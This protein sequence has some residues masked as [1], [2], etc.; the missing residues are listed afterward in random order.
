MLYRQKQRIRIF[1]KRSIFFGVWRNFYYRRS[2]QKKQVLL[3]TLNSRHFV[4]WILQKM[5]KMAFDCWDREWK[6]NKLTL[7]VWEGVKTYAT[8]TISDKNHQTPIWCIMSEG[9]KRGESEYRKNPSAQIRKR[10]LFYRVIRIW[11]EQTSGD[12]WVFFWE[13]IFSSHGSEH[14]N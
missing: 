3:L 10:N 2:V 12:G 14:F 8:I 11:K 13:Y 5:S 7:G 6:G 4:W 9:T 1:A